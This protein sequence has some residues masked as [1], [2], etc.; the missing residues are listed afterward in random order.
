MSSKLEQQTLN[1]SIYTFKDDLVSVFL[2]FRPLFNKHSKVIS[3]IAKAVAIS[4]NILCFFLA[5]GTSAAYLLVILAS[6]L[7]MLVSFMFDLAKTT[8]NV[9]DNKLSRRSLKHVLNSKQKA[10][11]KQASTLFVQTASNI[12][13]IYIS[14]FLVFDILNLSYWQGLFIAAGLIL[15]PL[16]SLFLAYILKLFKLDNLVEQLHL[17]DIYMYVSKLISIE[18]TIAE[19]IFTYTYNYIKR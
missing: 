4:L 2:Y 8:L 5:F 13:I 9:P 11:T 19:E 17:K 14:H 7:I 15:F 16:F 12:L 1:S 6:V 10:Y 18:E 3:F